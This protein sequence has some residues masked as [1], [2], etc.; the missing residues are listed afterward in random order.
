MGDLN[1]CVGTLNDYIPDD[2]ARHLPLDYDDILD[3]LPGIRDSLD[4]HVDDRG[5]HILEYALHHN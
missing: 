4:K 5:K 3:V 1:S 2:T